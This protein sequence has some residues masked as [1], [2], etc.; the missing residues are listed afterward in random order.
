MATRAL[1]ESKY[2]VKNDKYDSEKYGDVKPIESLINKDDIGSSLI[3][4]R[5]EDL[6]NSRYCVYNIKDIIRDGKPPG[7]FC[8]EVIYGNKQ[9]KL[10]FDID[11][12]IDISDC[13]TEDQVEN[14]GL[15]Q[16]T[17]IINEMMGAIIHVWTQEYYGETGL[18]LSEDDIMI[19]SSTGFDYAPKGVYKYKVSLHILVAPDIFVV[20]NNRE[21]EAFA[22]RV[23]ELLPE[24][25]RLYFDDGIYKSKNNLRM[26]RSFKTPQNVAQR[27]IREKII[28]GNNPRFGFKESLITYIDGLLIIDKKLTTSFVDNN[29]NNIQ[30]DESQVKSIKSLLTEEEKSTFMIRDISRNIVN[31]TRLRPSFCEFCKRTHDNDN[32]LYIVCDSKNNGKISVTKRC[33]KSDKFKVIGSIDSEGYSNIYINRDND[34]GNEELLNK[35]RMKDELV[36]CIEYVKKQKLVE[37]E[38]KKATF[39]KDEV[40]PD[41][42]DKLFNNSLVYESSLD[43]D[44]VSPKIK[45]IPKEIRFGSDNEF[46]EDYYDGI[47]D[48]ALDS[49]AMKQVNLIFENKKKENQEN[50]YDTWCS[51]SQKDRDNIE[52][53]NI[54]TN[55]YVSNKDED[56]FDKWPNSCKYSESVMRPFVEIGERVPKTLCV[57]AP[58]KMGKTKMLREF[59]RDH[60]ND[61]NCVI[62]I[63]TFRRTFAAHMHQRFSDLGFT[64][65]DASTGKL[66]DKRLIIQLESLHRLAIEPVDLVVM[67][68]SELIIEQINSGMFQQFVKAFASLDYLIKY[69]KHLIC[70][71]AYMSDRTYRVLD[72]MRGFNKDDMLFHFNNFKRDIGDKY[73][74]TKNIGAWMHH[75]AHSI[76]EHE[77]IAIMTNSLS[78]CK[79]IEQHVKQSAD[80][81]INIGIYSSETAK[82]VKNAAFN[83]VDKVWS[84]HDV[85]IITPTVSAGVS[86][87]L[88]HFDRVFGYFMDKSCPVETSIQML[89][90]V[91][92]VKSREYIIITDN[93][94]RKLPT[95][96]KE[97]KKRIQQQHMYLMTEIGN[98]RL[99]FTYDSDGNVEIRNTDYMQI[100][101]ENQ[102]IINLSKNNY[103]ERFI[104]IITKYGAEVSNLDI[105]VSNEELESIINDHKSIKTLMVE[106]EADNIAKSENLSYEKYIEI[107][108]AQNDTALDTREVTKDE[109]FAYKKYNFKQF[110]GI[111]DSNNFTGDDYLSFNKEDIKRHFINLNIINL[112]KECDAETLMRAMKIKD[113]QYLTSMDQNLEL[114][115]SDSLDIYK[116]K[117]TNRTNLKD[118]IKDH[119]IINFKN[120]SIIHDITH[121]LVTM[122]GWK[123]VLDTESKIP[124]TSIIVG[125][126]QNI[127]AIKYHSNCISSILNKPWI[128]PDPTHKEYYKESLKCLNQILSYVYGIRVIKDKKVSHNGGFHSLRLKSGFV[129]S[130]KDNKYIIPGTIYTGK[131][132]DC[133]YI[134][135]IKII[136]DD[137]K[138]SREIYD[139]SIMKESIEDI[140][141]ELM[142]KSI[143]KDSYEIKV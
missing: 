26:L 138:L 89:G 38:R 109:L 75:V 118:S 12:N 63:L 82:S 1:Y 97:L 59:I 33:R 56:L 28:L 43:D 112:I 116:N 18:L 2:L 62:R 9:Q 42:F 57:R 48:S 61:P 130:V 103:L 72:T 55:Y 21:A 17:L 14:K 24:K 114:F 76:N 47:P 39:D 70:M 117:L 29:S 115:H 10:R 78:E 88:E 7:S 128:F 93:D 73:L 126:R 11:A 74:M 80:F 108:D 142:D 27:Y 139:T 4:I 107:K 140:D 101:L 46:T 106:N 51:L 37:Q 129:Y 40:S 19:M 84:K 20:A 8:H 60:F 23:K 92:N 125:L 58:M 124:F 131:S 6:N 91:R 45:V 122:C 83:D 87:E 35:F 64:I 13:S 141:D 133:N 77:K 22:I 104:S 32:T 79:T 100:W 96:I 119:N 110:Y 98:S 34:T 90:R 143:I 137:I 16:Q 94:I 113:K 41:D 53:N 134:N 86:F 135:A 71:D 49:E 85:L 69:S 136:I 123:N 3:V 120:N 44:I 132:R 30:I 127:D 81:P 121:K 99:D 68:E 95:N 25:I 31:F 50:L 67:D 36:S 52:M 105:G 5:H 65:Y 15:E 102:R 66:S 54:K 111:S